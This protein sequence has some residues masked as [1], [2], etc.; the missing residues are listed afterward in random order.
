L[1]ADLAT[2][3]APG[4]EDPDARAVE[5]DEAKDDEKP[6]AQDT[7][8]PV[9]PATPAKAKHSG[10]SSVAELKRIMNDVTQIKEL[11]QHLQTLSHEI[12]GNLAAMLQLAGAQGVQLT[13]WGRAV[14]LYPNGFLLTEEPDG[15]V[16]SRHLNDL[17]PAQLHQLM[18]Q[19]IPSIRESLRGAKQTQESLAGD[20][21]AI[22]DTLAENL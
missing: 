14:T 4:P 17:K 5:P 21:E 10:P 12:T 20:L 1:A 3:T 8:T 2:V 15:V 9:K 18:Q 11:R 7:V 13:A 6:N 22:H 19:L 16:Q